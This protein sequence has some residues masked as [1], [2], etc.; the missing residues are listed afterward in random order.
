[1]LPIGDQN[2]TRTTPVVNYLLLALNLVAFV[3]EWL[4]IAGGG[5]AWVVPGYG[6]VPTRFVAD[7]LGEAFTLFT[8]MFMHGGWGHLGGNLLYLYI[9][10]DNV[11]DALGHFK[12]LLFYLAAGVAAG[13]LQIA[14]GPSSTIPMVG[15]S[16][17]IAG[18]LGAYIVLYPKA[19]ITLLNPVPLLWL[20]LGFLIVLPAWLV[21]GM[22]FVWQLLGGVGQLGM[23][24]E[25]GVAF[26]AHVG[27]FV[28]G[29]LLV[30]R[31]AVRRA[32]HARWSH[33]KPPSRRAGAFPS[34]GSWP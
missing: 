27:G 14:M 17:A 26:F 2:P 5:E 18:T 4:L 31:L 1:M 11:E 25:G 15:A 13:F 23:E 33:W 21:I 30:K 7:P 10:G 6:L 32:D 22:W 3:W 19:P 20:F 29:A 28:A 16:G 24:A 12:Y 8:S 9:F 34:R